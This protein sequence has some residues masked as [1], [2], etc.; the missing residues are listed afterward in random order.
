MCQACNPGAAAVVR[1]ADRRHFLK[2]SAA[3]A[4]LVALGA[5][6]VRAQTPTGPADAIFFG[7]TIRTMVGEHDRVEAVAVRQGRIVAVGRKSALTA[8]SGPGTQMIDLGAR[9]LLPG[10]VDAHMHASLTML[11]DWLDMGPFA[12]RTIDEALGKLKTAAAEAKPGEWLRGQQFD[13]SLMKGT[14]PTREILDGIA[15]DNPVFILESNG[16]IAYANS[17]GFAAAGI[18]LDAPDPANGRYLKDADGKMLGRMEEAPA[19]TPFFFKMPMPKPDETKARIRR[20]FDRASAIG[21]TALHDCSVGANAYIAQLTEV[22][23]DGPIR[24]GGFLTGNTL[25]K[26]VE[27]GLKPGTGSDKFRLN[28]IKF[29][30]DGSNQARTG[31]QREPY[32]NSQS[33]GS[34]NYAPEQLAAGIGKAHG[35]GWQVAVHANGDAAIDAVLDAYQGVLAKSP[36]ADHRHRI[37]HCS[38]LHPEQMDRMAGLGVSPSFLIGHVHYWGRA[39]RD[40]ILGP[41]RV[42][43]YDPCAS[44][45]AHRLRI[46]LHSDYNVTPIDPLRCVDNAVNRTMRDGGGTL[47]PAER[48]SVRQALRAVTIDA[49]WQCRMD[50]TAGSI[51]TGKY[52]DFVVLDRDPLS[53]DPREIGQVKV[54]ETWLAGERRYAA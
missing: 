50:D 20:L 44:A 30:A 11:D 19:Y 37:E 7:G 15:P 34:A 27:A 28:G 23:A 35:L 13:P 32:L 39:F 2:S 42:K 9:A 17:K 18:A 52:A 8:L 41:A 54:R 14:A 45:L 51:E 36:R 12:N 4:S 33:R 3:L 24:L 53:V 38:I 46:S 43:H 1:E 10:F 47:N 6:P 22:T 31:F 29:W 25:D 26:W 49:A 5:A 21:C 40:D 48:I 16:H